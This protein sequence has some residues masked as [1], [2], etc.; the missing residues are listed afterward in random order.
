MTCLALDYTGT[1]LVSGS[2]DTTCMI[3]QITQEYESSLNIDPKPVHILYGHT[4]SVTSVDISIE[5]DM[6]VSGSLDG[7]INI[8]TVRKGHFVKS[9]SF[10][11]EK[12]SKFIN[13]TVK[14]SNQRHI[15]IYT[16]SLINSIL[17]L[18]NENRNIYELYLFSINGRLISYEK[19]AHPI[20]DMIIK[21]DYCILAVLMNQNLLNQYSNTSKQGTYVSKIIFKENYE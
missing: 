13:L 3:W 11:N 18:A 20:Q 8:H 12:I 17:N 2:M 21:D 6:M 1:L 10:Q 9:I 5:L 7:T 14:L 19:L 16:S 15:L 4:D